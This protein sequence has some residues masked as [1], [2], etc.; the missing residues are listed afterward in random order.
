MRFEICTDGAAGVRAA[1][2]AGA[3]RVELCASL[4]E[5]GLTPSRGAMRQA[6]RVEGIGLHVIIRPRGGD[7]CPDDDEF[8]AMLTDIATA[9]QEGAD[10]AV[11]G[12]LT[13]EGAVD[14]PRTTRLIEA[15]RPMSVTFHRAFDMTA[16]PFAALEALVELGVDRVLTSG[17]AVSVLEGLP[18]ITRLIAQAGSRLI[19]M[20]GGGITAGNIGRI[21]AVARP[22]EIHV[23]AL[24][25]VASPMRYQ[26]GGVFMGG[27]LRQPEY[28]VHATDPALLGQIMAAAEG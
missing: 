21:V 9:K 17:Q 3:H 11:F 7:F 18:L 16:D 24:A 14:G 8:A 19:V 23:A 6:R 13:L 5:G 10:G 15:A 28:A 27:E 26:R 22:A 20:P 25:P 12:C 1:Q 4:F 2:R